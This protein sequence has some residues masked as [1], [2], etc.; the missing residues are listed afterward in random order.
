MGEGGMME[1]ISKLIE[2]IQSRIN[3]LSAGVDGK[4]SFINGQIVG[5][6]V[7]REMVDLWSKKEVA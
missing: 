6:V 7:A 3:E 5:L 1:D 2:R 4:G